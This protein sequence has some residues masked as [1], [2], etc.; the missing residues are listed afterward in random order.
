MKAGHDSPGHIPKHK[1]IFVLT[2]T[3]VTVK[4]DLFPQTPLSKKVMQITRIMHLLRVIETIVHYNVSTGWFIHSE[5]KWPQVI[6]PLGLPREPR[7]CR[8]YVLHE[9]SIN[10]VPAL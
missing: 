8:G 5:R 4:M 2:R 6:E 1:L 9:R 10:E 3:V 7:S